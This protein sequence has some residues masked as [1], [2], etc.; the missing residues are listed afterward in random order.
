[1]AWPKGVPR[2]PKE[3]GTVSE[4]IEVSAEIETPEAV[5]QPT[6][7]TP[8]MQALIAAMQGQML[9]AVAEMKKPSAEEQKKLDEE[10]TRRLAIAR[11]AVYAERKR[12]EDSK[13]LQEGC[14]HSKPNGTTSFTA[15]GNSDECYRAF[16]PLCRYISP[17]IRMTENQKR[18]GL[19]FHKLRGVT[20]AQLEAAA[21]RS[22][23]PVPPQP[24]PFGFVAESL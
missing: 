2:K 1:M 18:E 20:I 7:L 23:P 19:N 6:A 12:E 14:S 21:A 24:V 11:N 9:A 15:Q 3:D 4:E 22:L 8:E 13:G 17:P 16:C 5:P 10:R